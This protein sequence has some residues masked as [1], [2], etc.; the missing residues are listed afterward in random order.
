MTDNRVLGGVAAVVAALVLIP[1][2]SG[3]AAGKQDVR[4]VNTASEPIPTSAQGIT[5][6]TGTVGVDPSSNTV[7]VSNLPS[8]PS[9]YQRT[10]SFATTGQGVNC[11]GLPRP[12]DVLVTVNN[13]AVRVFIPFPDIEVYAFMRVHDAS[14]TIPAPPIPLQDAEGNTFRGQ[15]ETVLYDG[16]VNGELQSLSLCVFQTT[17]LQVD[18]SAVF[19]GTQL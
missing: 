11:A 12:A 3:A 13:V 15:I 5:Q 17:D 2:I 8:T 10:L 14:R 19:S 4:V 9:P 16:T 18:V 1:N 7:Q 6:V